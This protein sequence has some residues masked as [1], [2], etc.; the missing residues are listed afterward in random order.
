VR[1]D[2]GIGARHR[3][4]PLPQ[5]AAR[6]QSAVAQRARAI[7]EDNVEI[8]RQLHVLKSVIEDEGV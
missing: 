6:K 4:W 3:R 8:A 2:N 5:I 7:E 1:Q